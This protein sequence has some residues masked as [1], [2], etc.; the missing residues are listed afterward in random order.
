VNAWL[1]AKQVRETATERAVAAE[2]QHRELRGHAR[3]LATR[4]RRH[5]SRERTQARAA[6]LD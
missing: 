1:V 3:I 2:D 4:R 5:K 6:G